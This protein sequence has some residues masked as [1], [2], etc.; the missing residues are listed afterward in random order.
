[1]LFKAIYDLLSNDELR[2]RYG[3]NGRE[4]ILKGFSWD[5]ITDETEQ[6]YYNILSGN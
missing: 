5:H 6:I 4:K 2:C 3:E 1:M